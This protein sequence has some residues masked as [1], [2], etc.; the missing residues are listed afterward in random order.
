MKEEGPS[1]VLSTLREDYWQTVSGESA[2][3]ETDVATVQYLLFRVGDRLFAFETCYCRQVYRV[4]AIVPVPRV[5]EHVMG[6]INVRGRVVSVTS[7]NT[8]FQI[9]GDAT[10]PTAR[11][12]VI[13]DQTASTAMLVDLVDKIVEIRVDEIQQPGFGGPGREFAT[14]EVLVDDKLV[15]LLSV[16][17]VMSAPAMVIDFRRSEE[18]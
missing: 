16:P 7:L 17:R 9:E 3:E 13:S 8:L 11:L 4:P 18:R 12:I 15:V 1:D 14:G 2:D 5:P 10:S 6:I